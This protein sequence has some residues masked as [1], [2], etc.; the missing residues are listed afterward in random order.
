M[1]FLFANS[2]R[3]ELTVSILPWSHFISGS[4][5]EYEHASDS[6]N[7]EGHVSRKRRPVSGLDEEHERALGDASESSDDEAHLSHTPGS[8]SGM[9]DENMSPSPR[10]ADG[11]TQP[12]GSVRFSNKLLNLNIINEQTAPDL[13]IAITPRP[14]YH[15][16]FH[17]HVPSC[18][19]V[20]DDTCTYGEY[21]EHML[22]HDSEL[23]AMSQT[24]V[25]SDVSLVLLMPLNSANMFSWIALP[26]SLQLVNPGRS[27][28][29][30]P[31]ANRS[32]WTRVQCGPIT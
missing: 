25:R 2:S 9:G 18:T 12:Q 4:D 20:R 27:H 5:E 17:C 13:A 8:V 15:L 16:R 26:N 24:S 28:A 3:E 10:E 21:T 1:P 6:F 32:I 22:L 23:Y 29:S 30:I 7:D 14:G 31:D 19:M 11:E